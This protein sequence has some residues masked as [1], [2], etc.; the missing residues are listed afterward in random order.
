MLV[1]VVWKAMGEGD[2]LIGTVQELSVESVFRVS[3]RVAAGD[4]GRP[5]DGIGV[6]PCARV[7]AGGKGLG[8]GGS[9]AGSGR[10]S[11]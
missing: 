2:L 3:S 7:D 8:C 6:V 9:R 1:S 10:L 5:A 11:M 4:V